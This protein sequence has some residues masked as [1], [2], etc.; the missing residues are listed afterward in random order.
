[1]EVE[2]ILATVYVSEMVPEL[3]GVWWADELDDGR[4][5]PRGVVVSGRIG[6][7]VAAA[8]KSDAR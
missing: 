3:D 4:W 1:M 2:Q 8:R 5:A 7:W 6:D